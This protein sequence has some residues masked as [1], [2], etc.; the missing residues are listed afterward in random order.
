MYTFK[1][2]RIDQRE[3]RI[4]KH[5]KLN[6]KIVKNIFHYS[7]FF[8]FFQPVKMFSEIVQAGFL[9]DLHQIF[10]ITPLEPQLE[11]QQD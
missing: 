5:H 3:Q 10:R 11:W 7:L 2:A 6:D 1:K 4:D 9:S 8:I